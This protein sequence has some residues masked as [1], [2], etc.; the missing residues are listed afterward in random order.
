[1][2]QAVLIEATATGEGKPLVR[3]GYAPPPRALGGCPLCR[4]PLRGSFAL[5]WCCH[6]STS[7]LGSIPGE[8]ASPCVKRGELPRVLP[9]SLCAVGDPLHR[10]LRLYK[11]AP[12]I[13]ARNHFTSLVARHLEH[14]LS[15][16]FG[17]LQDLAGGCVDALAVVPST[18]R[19][20]RSRSGRGTDPVEWIVRRSQTLSALQ[21]VRLQRGVETVRHLGP[22][23]AGFEVAT[24]VRAG[25][26]VVV[27]DDT[28]TTGAHALSAAAALERAGANV[29]AILVIGRIIDITAGPDVANWWRDVVSRAERAE[30]SGQ[31]CL[32]TCKLAG[33][34]APALSQ[35]PGLDPSSVTAPGNGRLDVRRSADPRAEPWCRDR[36]GPKGYLLPHP[37]QRPHHRA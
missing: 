19:G 30:P 1:V 15:R 26:T 32:S 5:C 7:L 33:R 13:D 34:S 4:G 35:L 22:S 28:W 20:T 17:C 36:S 6:R 21:R 31:C 23:R 37:I 3:L 14:F 2:T 11:D 24:Q 8:K 10:A 12:A 18:T 27:F 29:V 9:V 25:T 16:H